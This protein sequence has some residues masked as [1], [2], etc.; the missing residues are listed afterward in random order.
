MLAQSEINHQ[1]SLHQSAFGISSESMPQGLQKL[2]ENREFS[3]LRIGQHPAVFLVI[4]SMFILQ[5]DTKT[6]VDR[7]PGKA[8]PIGN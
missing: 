5:M 8:T 2:S 4:L 1:A 6:I 7:N 3:R